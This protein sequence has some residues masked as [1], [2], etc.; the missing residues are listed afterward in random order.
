MH[1]AKHNMTRFKSKLLSLNAT[2]EHKTK[3]FTPANCEELVIPFAKEKFIKVVGRLARDSHPPVTSDENEVISGV[4]VRNE[5]YNMSLMNPADLPEYAGLPI[6]RVGERIHVNLGIGP[7]LIKY[8]LAGYF[9]TVEE[10]PSPSPA[11]PEKALTNGEKHQPNGTSSNKAHPDVE[12]RGQIATYLIMSSILVYV[13]DG[14][15]VELVWE[16]NVTSDSI[17]DAVLG[18]VTEIAMSPAGIKFSES[19]RMN[20]STHHHHANGA[21][22]DDL[23]EELTERYDGPK[24]KRSIFADAGGIGLGRLCTL[25]EAQF[26]EDNIAPLKIPKRWY[27][28]S[29]MSAFGG[30]ANTEAVQS[31][32]RKLKISSNADPEA[33]MNGDMDLDDAIEFTAEEKALL[34]DPE[35]QNEIKRLHGQGIVV[36]GFEV[37]CDKA[38]AR[39]WLEDLSVE[40]EGSRVWKE[41]VAAVVKGAAGTVW[42]VNCQSSS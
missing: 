4:L 1:G 2:K 6:T 15:P 26:G 8:G 17:A 7:E 11:H 3:I 28:P 12:S 37:R 36:P 20:G 40:C 24:G 21:E 30:N 13:F 32:L 42:V 41:R 34:Q 27:D 35:V 16:G 31:S 33:T 10:L 18:C 23:E 39:V 29:S 5:E 22:D 9:G 25:L 38:V 19:N 14:G